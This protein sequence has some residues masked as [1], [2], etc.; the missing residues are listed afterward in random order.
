M[1]GLSGNLAYIALPAHSGW[2]LLCK[3]PDCLFAA[4]GSMSKEAWWAVGV[5]GLGF[6]GLEC[7]AYG[8]WK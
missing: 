1:T 5:W 7:K 4:S 2:E 8:L 3:G 6:K